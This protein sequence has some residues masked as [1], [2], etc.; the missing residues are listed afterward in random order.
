MNRMFASAAVLSTS[1]LLSACD[2]GDLPVAMNGVDGGP[3]DGASTGS[4]G[5]A[6]G[7]GGQG[8]DGASAGVAG[9]A[10]GQTGGAAGAGGSGGSAGDAG[11]GC[12]GSAPPCF[13]D[14]LAM[15]CGQ[16]PA[17][18]ATCQGGLWMCGGAEAPGCNGISCILGSK[19]D[20]GGV[21]A[22]GC[23]DLVPV[24]CFGTDTSKCCG[25][26]PIG[27]ATCECTGWK[28]GGGPAP[29]CNGTPCP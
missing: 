5:G 11:G 12:T 27:F 8:G 15:C 23:V 24:H 18:R 2:T 19:C 13:G 3:T 21:D 7:S 28:C 10:G 20:A 17:G 26:D 14:N 25:K 1:I 29:G 16:D 6:A 9:S 22:G 4:Q